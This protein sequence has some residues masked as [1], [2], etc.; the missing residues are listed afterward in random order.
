MI[1]SKYGY[2]SGTEA[3]IYGDL[4]KWLKE[5]KGNHKKQKKVKQLKKLEFGKRSNQNV[6]NES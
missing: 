6:R 3:R 1:R 5:N 2:I 4:D